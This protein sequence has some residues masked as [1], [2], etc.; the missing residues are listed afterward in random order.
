MGTAALVATR[1][2]CRFQRTRSG[3][4]IELCLG[5][6][7]KKQKNKGPL[8][9]GCST[10]SPLAR[11]LRRPRRVLTVPRNCILRTLKRAGCSARSDAP[12]IRNRR[13]GRLPGRSSASNS[14]RRLASWQKYHLIIPPPIAMRSRTTALEIDKRLIIGVAAGTVWH[15]L[16]GCGFAIRRACRH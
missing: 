4:L 3:W 8:L 5:V 13:Y 15:S 12:P 1:R 10:T 9:G 2:Q 7:R 14:S 6:N 16:I 11:G